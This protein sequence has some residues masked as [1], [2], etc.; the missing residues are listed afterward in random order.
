V[1][2]CNSESSKK[3]ATFAKTVDKVQQD[4]VDGACSMHGTIR[5]KYKICVGKPE[6]MIPLGRARSRYEDK[7]GTDLKEAG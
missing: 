5:N 7:I 1:P 2:L 6:G 3:F 4:E